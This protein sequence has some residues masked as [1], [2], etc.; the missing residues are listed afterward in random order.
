MNIVMR[1]V[2]EF[3]A[4]HFRNSLESSIYL[5]WFRLSE[6]LIYKE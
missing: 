3:M 1:L 5:R 4:N 6:T 2:V